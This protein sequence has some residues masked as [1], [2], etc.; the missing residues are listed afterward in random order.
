MTVY[1]VTIP[2]HDPLTVEVADRVEFT[3]PVTDT[4][5]RQALAQTIGLAVLPKLHD[6][7]AAK[8]VE[9]GANNQIERLIDRPATSRDVL[10]AYVGWEVAGKH[11]EAAVDE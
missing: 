11:L 6:V 3:E 1:D 8:E 7:P 10:A 9:R 4:L 2:G 5:A